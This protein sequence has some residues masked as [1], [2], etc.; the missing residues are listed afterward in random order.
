[1]YY[2]IIGDVHGHANELRKLLEALGYQE[3]ITGFAHPTRKAIFLGDYI[4]RGPLQVEVYRI[5]RAMVEGGHAQAIMG[6]HEY[7]AVAFSTP[8]PRRPGHHLREQSEKNYRQHHEFLAQVGDGSPLH[9]EMLDWFRRLPL[10]LDLGAFKVIHACWHPKHIAY[11]PNVLDENN[12]LTEAGWL[13]SAGSGSPASD[14]VEL[15]LK[16]SEIDLPDSV[17]YVDKDGNSRRKARTRWWLNAPM[18]IRELLLEVKHLPVEHSGLETPPSLDDIVGH[19]G[20]TLI[21]VGHYWRT[22]APEVLSPHVA[23]LDYSIAK[24]GGDRK[25]CAYRWSGETELSNAN[26]VCV[27]P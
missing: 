17:E 5:V 24:S 26:F 25:L 3:T 18:T 27:I 21:F 4:D 11:A 9:L 12:C 15:L 13:E 7:N 14:L 2:D 19:D 6:N 10:F 8:D 1:M 22:G 20:E 23:C 16:G